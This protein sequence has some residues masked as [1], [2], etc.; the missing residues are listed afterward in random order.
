MNK[1]IIQLIKV[2]TLEGGETKTQRAAAVAVDDAQALELT[3]WQGADG[4][5]INIHT[6]GMSDHPAQLLSMES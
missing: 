5:R 6:V 4:T 2:E 3:G 1:K